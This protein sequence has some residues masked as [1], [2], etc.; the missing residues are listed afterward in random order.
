MIFF[1]VLYMDNNSLI[2]R[3]PALPGLDI[4]AEVAVGID[5][6][7]I[8]LRGE[9]S[10]ARF[11]GRAPTMYMA[12]AGGIREGLSDAALVRMFGCHHRTVAAIREREAVGI[13]ADRYRSVQGGKLRMA[14]MGLADEINRRI[15][16]GAE[17]Q[18]IPFKDLVQG[19]DKLGGMERLLAGEPN[20]IVGHLQSSGGDE[21]LRELVAAPESIH[22]QA[23]KKAAGS[24]DVAQARAH[25][26][27]SIAV[28]GEMIKGAV[29]DDVSRGYN[30]QTVEN[31][32]VR[33]SDTVEDTNGVERCLVSGG[34]DRRNGDDGG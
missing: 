11:F 19:V 18:E 16:S 8:A 29:R 23:K 12:I 9:Y 22:S 30:V 6:R 20:Q 15:F 2:D 10:A 21:D 33:K 4:S 5:E 28:P 17:V 27:G 3:E 25:E 24:L 32:G 13:E 31:Q 7:E 1:G 26:G 34:V 14:T